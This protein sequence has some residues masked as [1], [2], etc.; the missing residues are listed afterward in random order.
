M[1]SFVSLTLALK[2]LFGEPL[3]ALPKALRQRVKTEFSLIPWCKL[4][5]EDRRIVALQ[6]DYPD[7]PETEQERRFW[8][9]WARRKEAIMTQITKW[10]AIASPTALDLAQKETRLPE[11]RQELARLEAEEFVGTIE[12]DT[13][14]QPLLIQVMTIQDYSDVGSR[15]WRS[16]NARNAANVLHDKPGGSRDKK[17]QIREIWATGR[18][19]S[20]DMCAEQECAA[21]EMSF[22][23]AR[24]ALKN[25]PKPSRC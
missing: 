1:S 13:S 2:G 9:D 6:C 22:S 11:L 5:A 15:E 7:D 21:L 17:R 19:T 18:Y 14:N 16:Q 4:S 23:T 20:K 24:L 10:K 8:W 3:S 12:S 25:I